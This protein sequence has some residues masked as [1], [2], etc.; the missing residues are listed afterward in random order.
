MTGWERTQVYSWLNSTEA[1][2]ECRDVGI[3]HVSNPARPTGSS[4][5]DETHLERKNK[6]QLELNLKFKLNPKYYIG[7]LL[8]I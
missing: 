1:D 7:V 8:I 4:A 3:T 5:E 2:R 6:Y